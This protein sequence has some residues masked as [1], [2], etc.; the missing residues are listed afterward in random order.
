MLVV[1]VITRISG[2]EV[3]MLVEG[4][5]VDFLGEHGEGIVRKVAK[6]VMERMSRARAALYDV[7]KKT[8]HPNKNTVSHPCIILIPD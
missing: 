1:G 5:V 6:V 4:V 3:E 2:L 8:L 7:P